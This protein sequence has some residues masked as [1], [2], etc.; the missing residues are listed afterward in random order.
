MTNLFPE[1]DDHFYE[2]SPV[3]V[4]NG[5]LL[6]KEI[7]KA[8]FKTR[9]FNLAKKCTQKYKVNLFDSSLQNLFYLITNNVY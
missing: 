9:V 1:L 7:V 8:Y 6:I 2:S 4:N 3:G 5:F